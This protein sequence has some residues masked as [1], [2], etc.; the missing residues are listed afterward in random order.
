MR[1]ELVT[2]AACPVDAEQ[3][4]SI[5]EGVARGERAIKEGL[6]V[7]HQEAKKRMSRWLR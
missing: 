2:L 3:R 4:L 7:T 6:T 1:T 5:M